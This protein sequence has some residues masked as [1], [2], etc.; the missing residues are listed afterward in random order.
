MENS[1]FPI[2]IYLTKDLGLEFQKTNVRIR[3]SILM[4]QCVPTVRQMGQLL[5]FWTKFAQK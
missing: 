1:T 5:L 3:I 2:Q 4:I